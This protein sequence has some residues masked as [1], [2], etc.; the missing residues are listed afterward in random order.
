MLHWRGAVNVRRNDSVVVGEFGT[1]NVS[2]LIV[3][4][5]NKKLC[6]EL[7]LNPEVHYEIVYSTSS[8]QARQR[9]KQLSNVRLLP[10]RLVLL[11]PPAHR[12]SPTFHVCS[13]AERHELHESYGDVTLFPK[14]LGTDA[15]AMYMN[16]KQGQIVRVEWRGSIYYRLVQ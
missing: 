8:F 1:E 7:V 2:I 3:H 13:T 14:M 16:F 4:T 5:M 15:M 10:W 6:T 11:E 12:L 9:M